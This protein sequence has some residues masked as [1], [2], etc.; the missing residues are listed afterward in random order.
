MNLK[1]KEKDN[2]NESYEFLS[3]YKFLTVTE[4]FDAEYQGVTI[5][6]IIF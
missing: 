6:Y 1:I 4:K 5:K 3:S 2:T